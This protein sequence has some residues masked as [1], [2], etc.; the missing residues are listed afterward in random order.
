MIKVAVIRFLLVIMIMFAVAA[1]VPA[2]GQQRWQINKSRQLMIV[3]SNNWDKLQGKLYAYKKVKNKWVL[4][5]SNPVGL[6]SKGIGIGDGLVKLNVNGPVKHEGDKKSPAGIFS[7]GT[8]F[9]Y[10]P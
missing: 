2:V 4:Q 3:V 10:A 8:A 9:G 7:I 5:F 6:G 1:D